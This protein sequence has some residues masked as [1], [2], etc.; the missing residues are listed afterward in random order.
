MKRIIVAALLSLFAATPAVAANAKNNIGVGY[1]TDSPGVLGIHGEFDISSSLDNEPVSV[2]V[3]YKRASQTVTT[4]G[5]SST[6]T[7]TG[8]GVAGIYDLTSVFKINNPKIKPYAG[9]GLIFEKATISWANTFPSTTASKNDL[10]YVFGARYAFT[11]QVAGDVNFS[12]YGGL[13]L[14]VNFGF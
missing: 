13:T 9:L 4:F 7:E 2:Q 11:P 1:G 6:V 3:F 10:Y 5:I 14:G 12:Q 8:M